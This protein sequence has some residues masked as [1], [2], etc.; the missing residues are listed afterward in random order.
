MVI[1]Y[2]TNDRGEEIKFFQDGY[3]DTQLKIFKRAIEKHNTSAVFV[4]DGRSGMG[5]TTLANQVGITL[6]E[7][8]G[9]KNIYYNPEDFLKALKVAKKGEVLVFDEAMLISSR[10]ALSAINKM[11]VQAMSMIR[12]KRIYII[13]CVNSIFDLD[14]NL[15]ISRADLLL[16][17]YGKSLIDRGRFSAFFK[18]TDGR[19][20]IK[21]LYLNGKKFYTYGKP[22]CNYRGKFSKQFVVDDEE[23]EKQKQTGVNAFLT[24]SKG[25]GGTRTQAAFE[26]RNKLIRALSEKGWNVEQIVKDTGLK[27]TLQP[28]SDNA[29]INLFLL[30]SRL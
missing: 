27:K 20:R 24:G 1:I 25:T 15:A 28:F 6:Y 26:S 12:S 22:R 29:L 9:L 4:I 19:D 17:V 8:Y 23:Y 13:F 14:K 3:L 11:I 10:S 7:N 5:K 18:G 30:S 2:R 21:E 16:H